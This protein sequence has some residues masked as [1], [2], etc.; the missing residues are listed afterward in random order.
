MYG[1]QGTGK[2]SLMHYIAN[3][4]LDQTNAIIFFCDNENSLGSAIR[5]AK[6]IREVQENPII[7]IADEFERFAKD[8]ESEMK[9]FLDGNNSINNML[10]LASTNYI[11]KVPDT[12]KNRPSR[13]KMCKEIKGI[14]DKSVMRQIISDI[15]LK[16][17]PNLFTEVEID[18]AI[19]DVYSI[20]LD[21]L[22]HI[23]LNKAVDS[24]I[25]D[26][27]LI[28]KNTV[29]F[30]IGQDKEDN[31]EVQLGGVLVEKTAWLTYDKPTYKD[32]NP[33]TSI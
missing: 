4:L 12:L 15:S 13:F 10:F 17:D 1:C 21:E 2:T 23:C 24:Y 28:T 26:K 3:T 27:K 22:K 7:F 18:E 33:E 5:L 25:E 29:G 11:E 9:N 30:K 19:R 6:A 20:T 8:A 32:V 16:I 14:T 31:K